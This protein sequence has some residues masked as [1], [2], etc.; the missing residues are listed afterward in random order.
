[1]GQID[2][3]A[4]ATSLSESGCSK[5]LIT[6]S[7]YAFVCASLHWLEGLLKIMCF[8]TKKSWLVSIFFCQFSIFQ[9]SST[10][11]G[12]GRSRMLMLDSIYGGS[13]HHPIEFKQRVCTRR[14]FIYTKCHFWKN[15]SVFTLIDS[16]FSCSGSSIIPSRYYLPVVISGQF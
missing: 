5:I 14:N 2:L 1:M 6:I 9:R 16:I 7:L 8:S 12:S 4:S 15:C 13:T 10:K 3:T 11:H